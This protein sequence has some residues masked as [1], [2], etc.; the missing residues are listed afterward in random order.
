MLVSLSF[1]AGTSRAADHNQGRTGATQHFELRHLTA[2]IFAAG[3]LLWPQE[4]DAM[5]L[6]P[7]TGSIVLQAVIG[8]VAGGWLLFRTKIADLRARFASRRQ[9]PSEDSTPSDSA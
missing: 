6:D 9:E 7:G 3:A 8:A 2:L 5:Y 1:R 4:S